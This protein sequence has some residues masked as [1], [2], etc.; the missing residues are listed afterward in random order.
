MLLSQF[1]NF[2]LLEYLATVQTVFNEN[3][4][5]SEFLSSF[6]DYLKPLSVQ[7]TLRIVSHLPRPLISRK[8]H[9]FF[10]IYFPENISWF[11]IHIV[12]IVTHHVVTDPFGVNEK[13]EVFHLF[14]RR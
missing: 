1:S 7:N 14:K 10:L 2:S 8:F 5:R 4:L 12:H 13:M 3:Y 11:C 9:D 6:L